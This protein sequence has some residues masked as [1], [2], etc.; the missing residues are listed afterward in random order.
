[1]KRDL[2]ENTEFVLAE[3]N[4]STF[5]NLVQSLNKSKFTWSQFYVN[6]GDEDQEV[7]II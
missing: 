4:E 6:S 7:Y 2:G 1:M 3:D 5:N